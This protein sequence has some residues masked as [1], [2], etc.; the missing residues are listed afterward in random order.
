MSSCDGA[1]VFLTMGSIPAVALRVW[2]A[3]YHVMLFR[4]LAHGEII[5]SSA[6]GLPQPPRQPPTV[7]PGGANGW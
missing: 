6:P 5:R 4:R 7:G 3:P 2:P 1:A